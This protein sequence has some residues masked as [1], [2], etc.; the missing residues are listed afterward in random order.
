MNLDP[1]AE[2]MRRHSPYNYAFNNPIFF[3]DPDGMAPVDW[4]KNLETGKYEWNNSVTDRFS[5]PEGYKYVGKSNQSIVQDLFGKSVFRDS[6]SDTGTTSSNDVTTA[7]GW[8]AASDTAVTDSKMQISLRADV[9]EG[10]DFETG[11]IC[12]D[13]NGVVVDAV[14]S[15]NVR[16]AATPEGQALTLKPLSMTGN[17]VQMT[18][19]SNLSEGLN[20]RQANSSSFR[21]F[22]SAESIQRIKGK[23]TYELSFKG[24]YSDVESGTVLKSY[25][26]LFSQFGQNNYSRMNKKIELDNSTY[27]PLKD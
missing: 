14:V 6:T 13:F 25:G 9:T 23:G 11:E 17:G 16:S 27:L 20:F 26:L 24:L 2:Q 8:G 18:N 4:I 10:V 12:K 3:I 15:G 21:G 7:H 19:T 22:I 5:T 1:L